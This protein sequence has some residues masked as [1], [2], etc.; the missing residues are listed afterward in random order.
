MLPLLGLTIAVTRA[1]HQAGPLAG[2]LAE[3]GASVVLAPTIE[4]VDPEDMAPLDEAVAGLARYDWAIFTSANGVDRFF[5]RLSDAGALAGVRVA[6]IG[7]A[8]ASA[9]ARHGARADLVPEE[10]VAESLLASLEEAAPVAGRRF[11]IARAAVARD[12]LPDALRAAGAVVDVVDA[13]RTVR[14]ARSRELLSILLDRGGLDLT[15]FTSASTVTNFVDLVGARRAAG[16]RAASIGPI[17][18]A[19][20]REAGLD[21]AVEADEY[22]VAGLVAAIERWAPNAP[23]RP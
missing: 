16:A 4:I 15:T 7:T 12:V 14:P 9:L 23:P 18:S 21:V 22:T 11:L 10:Y 13:Y 5:A 19:A 20:A 2:A 1:A 6:A 8:T 17:T 3:R